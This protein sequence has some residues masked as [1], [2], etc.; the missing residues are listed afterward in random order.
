M[1][2]LI[3][4]ILTYTK[5]PSACPRRKAELVE[6]GLLV[7]AAFSEY[8]DP[9]SYHFTDT[10]TSIAEG[11]I[12][13]LK[14]TSA[15]VIRFRVLLLSSWVNVVYPPS[16]ALS[17]CSSSLLAKNRCV[18]PSNIDVA[19]LEDVMG[20]IEIYMERSLLVGGAASKLEPWQLTYTAFVL[21]K[22]SS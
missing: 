1:D 12:S 10:L 13:K 5:V 9:T 11:V 20:S 21:T 22:E 2:N 18:E 8:I 6:I 19:D 14:L 17:R 7:L 4:G 3:R 15:S 16:M